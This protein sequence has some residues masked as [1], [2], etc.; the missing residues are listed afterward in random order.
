MSNGRSE[1]LKFTKTEFEEALCRMCTYPEDHRYCPA[2]ITRQCEKRDRIAARV[3]KITS[4][5]NESIWEET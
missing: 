3:C 4:L 1:R 2:Y 5:E